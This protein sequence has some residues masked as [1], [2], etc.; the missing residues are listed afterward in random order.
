ML[1]V[2][3]FY[4]RPQVIRFVLLFGGRTGSTY[5]TTSLNSHPEI[6]AH[7]ESLDEFK[8]GQADLQLDRASQLLTPPFIGRFK[9]LGFKTKLVDILDPD[10]FVQLLQKKQSVIIHMRRRNHIKA[11]VSRL[12]AERLWRATGEWNLYDENNRLPPFS[13]D[14]VEFDELL[15]HR[16][17]V[18]IGLE[19]FIEELQLPTLSLSYEELISNEEA[20]TNRVF[21]FLHVAPRP[22]QGSTLKNTNDD[23]TQVVLNYDELRSNYIGT[24]YESM[25]NEILVPTKRPIAVK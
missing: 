4:V 19:K 25:F 21:S 17:K 5:L 7:G 2:R 11:V 10:G 6:C 24:H 23:L 8:P 12:N 13:I 15:E 20:V 1:M 22:L 9:V 16:E 18:D 3:K 14:P